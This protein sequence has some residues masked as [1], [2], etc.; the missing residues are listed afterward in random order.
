MTLYA[1]VSGYLRDVRVDKGDVVKQGQVLAVIESPETDQEFHAA[2]ADARN[3]R[4]IAARTMTLRAKGLVS[5]QEAEQAQSDADVTAAKLHSQEIQKGYET[6][7]APFPGT[8]T[9]R[10]ADTGALVQNATNSQASALPVVTVSQIRQLRVDVFLDQKDAPFV[11]KDEPVEITM[12]ERPE[13][14]ILGQV[15]RLS[16]EL[17]PRT[18]MML[19]EIDIPNEDRSLVAGSFVNVA[20]K[21]KSP[22]YTEAPVEAL[23]L[24]MNK[25][26]LTVVT[27]DNTLSYRPIEIASNDGKTLRVISGIKEGEMVALNVGDTIT[28]GGK[29]RPIVETPP[30]GVAPVATP[31][32]AGRSRSQLVP[33][34]VAANPGGQNPVNKWVGA[35]VGG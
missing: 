20:L 6:L 1:K 30:P 9:A 31:A 4:D 17:D 7:R 28:E 10:F 25:T 8:V 23:V 26:Y 16:N 14:K 33:S 2:F 13:F 18:K 3:K 35:S 34:A 21:I 19:V 27:P 29:V 15:D 22:P 12:A 24:R 32:A 11:V 5:E